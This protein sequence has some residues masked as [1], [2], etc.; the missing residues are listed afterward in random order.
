MHRRYFNRKNSEIFI[1]GVCSL[2]WHQDVDLNPF[3]LEDFK[4]YL[5]KLITELEKMMKK[6]E[7]YGNNYKN[8][9]CLKETTEIR[10]KNMTSRTINELEKKVEVNYSITLKLNN[11][12]LNNWMQKY[13]VN[14]VSSYWLKY[15][16]EYSRYNNPNSEPKWGC[17]STKENYTNF[18]WK[19]KTPIDEMIIAKDK[20]I[21]VQQNSLDVMDFN[22]NMY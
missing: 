17:K 20:V 10:N 3:S 8:L 9:S 4:L 1:K 12:I 22:R 14:S 18:N 19:T 13:S 2:W 16:I 21:K 6:I 15:W 11:M 5:N 7:K